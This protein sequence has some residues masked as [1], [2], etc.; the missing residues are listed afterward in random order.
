[1]KV[2]WYLYK[3]WI[4][5]KIIKRMFLKRHFECKKIVF[6]GSNNI[7]MKAIETWEKT[8]VIHILNQATT[9]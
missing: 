7:K 3:Q 5:L 2:L 1:M 4:F 6:Q 9:T 8:I